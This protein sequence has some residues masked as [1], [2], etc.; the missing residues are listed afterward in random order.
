M[1]S[2]GLNF[3]GEET[4]MDI[5][6]FYVDSQA[7]NANA[8]KNGRGLVLKKKF[9]K[10]NK[11]SDDTIIFGECSG[12]GKSNYFCSC[13]FIEKS[14]PVFRCSCPSRQF[15]CKHCLG[16]M[17]ALTDGNTFSVAEVPEDVVSKREKID[18]R[19]ENKKKR[20]A[21]PKKVNK[22]ALKK[23]IQAQLKGLDLLEKL[24]HDLVRTGMGN[25]NAKTARQI[26]EQAKQLGNAYL[27]GAQAALLSYTRLFVDDEGKFDGKMNATLREQ[28]YSQAM[29]QLARLNS[30]I[31]RGRQY[32]N[33]R[34]EDPELKP[35]T[36]T[37]IAAWLG[38]AWQLAE[39][40]QANLVEKDVSL[41]QV[42]FNSYDDVSRKEFVDTG[43]WV[44]L[45]SGQ[46]QL[47]QNFRPYRA[48]KFIKA[49]DSFFKVAEIE[50]LCVY[51]GDVNPR[52]RWETHNERN[53]TP[54]E[55][56]QIKSHAA[57][58]LA[59]LVKEMKGRMKAPLGDKQPI[60]AINYKKIG[61]LD[62]DTLVLEDSKG[63]RIVFTESGGYEEPE[64]CHL[65]WFLPKEF[66]S[67]QTLVGR[68]HHDF[69]AGT[70]RLKPLSLVTPAQIFRLSF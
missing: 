37:P 2:H 48:V 29:D 7:P 33:S 12:S 50:E 19:K 9:V 36:Q 34:A 42:A 41:V 32:L 25:T 64:S 58:D 20:D 11:S 24:T 3:S 6:E 16:L 56:K 26:E 49:D 63:T 10:L 55:L 68:L 67:N 30:I 17:Y 54:A 61:R 57:S 18:V 53:V 62:D 59:G 43:I 38:H 51:P 22:A 47:T 39:L 46:I 14:K 52:I 35:D 66:L 21:T 27:P 13:D 45:S 15:P 31:K 5:D 1:N 4:A 40:R 65:M 69:D 28:A 44:N 70:L 8:I 60:V 23:K